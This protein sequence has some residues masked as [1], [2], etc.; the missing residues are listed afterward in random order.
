MAKL[1]VFVGRYQPSKRQTSLALIKISTVANKCIKYTFY[2]KFTTS[3]PGQ[4]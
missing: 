2:K 4:D 1:S 3:D